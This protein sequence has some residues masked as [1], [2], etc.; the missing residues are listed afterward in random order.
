MPY[1]PHHVAYTVRE[2]A[3]IGAAHQLAGYDGIYFDLA[4][5]LGVPMATL[6]DGI[7]SACKRHRVPLI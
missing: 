6:D 2:V 4:R 5:R 1:V 3:D 7:A